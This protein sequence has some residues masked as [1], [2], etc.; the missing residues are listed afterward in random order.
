MRNAMIRYSLVA[1]IALSGLRAGSVAAQ[2]T[3]RP[4]GE[5]GTRTLQGK[6]ISFDAATGDLKLAWRHR[7]GHG[8]M[9]IVVK[10]DSQAQILAGGNPATRADLQP[11]IQVALTGQSKGTGVN[12]HFLVSKVEITGPAATAPA[13]ATTGVVHPDPQ[14]NDILDRLER[15]KIE[16]VETPIRFT[17]IDPILEDK[18]VF[19]GILR[20]KQDQPNPRFFIHFDKFTQEGITREKLEWH[21]FDGQWYIE[22]RQNTNTI[23]KRQIVRPGEEINVFRIGQGP[24]PLPFGQRKADILKYF[25]VKLV[26]ATDKDPANSVHLECTPKPG[27]DMAEKYGSVHFYIDKRSDMPVT[28]RTIEKN[29][30][31]EV[32]AEFP[33]DQIKLNTGMAASHLNL[34]DLPSYQVDTIPLPAPGPR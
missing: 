28:V 3:T 17:K 26:P 25:D 6:V 16:D 22:A 20:F 14:V 15:K 4:A 12:N 13:Q 19:Q 32:M 27:T 1:M 21:V 31:V 18:Q 24:F 34:P 7:G 10:V 30:N 8:Q 33:P 11:G 9:E 29:E 23:V 5:T 2:T